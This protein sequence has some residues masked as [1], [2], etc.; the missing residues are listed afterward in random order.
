MKDIEKSEIDSTKKDVITDKTQEEVAR[1]LA[2]DKLK[3]WMDSVR[4]S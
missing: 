3:P 2:K 4:H 1:E